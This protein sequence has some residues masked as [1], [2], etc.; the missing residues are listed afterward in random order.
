MTWSRRLLAA[1]GIAYVFTG[2]MAFV[3]PDFAAA[4]FPWNVSEFVAMTIGGWTLGIGLM[5]LQ[6][7][8]LWRSGGR[9]YP[10]LVGA[11]LFSAFELLV[12]IAFAPLLRTDQF[13]TIP[14]L[15]ALGLGTASGLLGAR[16]WWAMRRELVV[17][18]EGMPRWIFV[19]Y[20]LFVAVT[21]LLT[22][23]ALLVVPAGGTIFP[24]P[25]GAFTTRAFAAFFAA[26][27]AGAVPLLF[28]RDD[29]PAAHYARAGLYPVVLILAA[30]ISYLDLFD[31]G[32]RPGGLIYI[33]AYAVTAIA[34]MSIVYW[35]RRQSEV[36]WR[37]EA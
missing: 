1:S 24:E 32:A 22:V 7:T 6:A 25:L 4:N 17:E 23:A 13:L 35:H 2:L 28:T 15:A 16:G 21:A 33:G 29:E 27:G 10:L 36:D 19:T 12:V 26:L 14:Y 5:A 8:R 3:L 34:A 11:W 20:A 31:F 37:S 18:G 30:A 9:P